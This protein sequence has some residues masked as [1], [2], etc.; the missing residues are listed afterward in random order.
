MNMFA[1]LTT[2]ALL[3]GGIVAPAMAQY[4]AP[5]PSP[6]PQ[7]YPPGYAYQGQGYNNGGGIGQ[8]I[9]QLL[10]NRYNVT[11]RS[12]VSRCGGVSRRLRLA[13]RAAGLQP[14]I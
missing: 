3:A 5:Y 13:L 14:G 6:Y 1:R 2:A 7:T 8:I 12:A 11:D 10:G 4:P 9:D